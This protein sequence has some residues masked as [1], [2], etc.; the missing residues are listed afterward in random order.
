MVSTAWQSRRAGSE[1]LIWS[2]EVSGVG[3]GEPWQSRSCCRLSSQ[4]CAMQ[5]LRWK[6]IQ[7]RKAITDN[8]RLMNTDSLE[9]ASI[10]YL[11]CSGKMSW[12]LTELRSSKTESLL[13]MQWS[14]IR[15][16]REIQMKRE[17]L[18]IQLVGKIEILQLKTNVL[19]L[20]YMVRWHSRN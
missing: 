9:Y 2:R 1:H 19:C 15:F 17:V 6:N 16:V 3:W 18:K 13:S 5:E 8:E 7:V 10:S 20:P 14:K 12:K 11:Y 4:G